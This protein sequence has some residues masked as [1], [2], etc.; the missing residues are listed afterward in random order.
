[1]KITGERVSTPDGGFN[2]T[3]QRHAAAY[4]LAEPLLP[5]G[6]VVDLGCG[7]GHSFRLLAPRAT[8][9]V[10]V[11]PEALAGQERETV[12]ADMRRLPFAD[13]SFDAAIAVQSIEHVPDPETALSEAA[14]VLR[15]GGVAI[16][17]TPNR[18][19]FGRPD[20]II[21]PFHYVELDAQELRALCAR[22]FE[23]VEAAGIFGSPR[24]MEIFTAERLKL[25]RLLRLDPLRARRLL[26]RRGRQGLYDLL[27][28]RN[29][30][31]HDPRAAAI[32]I[33]D[34]E[35]GRENL[36]AALDV[37]AICSKATA[38]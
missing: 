22:A 25:D 1:M 13:E 16:F 28:R 8:V 31:A 11:D 9:G 6:S 34:F 24:Y 20:E 17:V 37:V 32:A 4:A 26:P 12:E 10:D 18:L 30:R 36:Q 38:G 27:L 33:A 3:W 29:R 15:P 35:L 14:R 5:A 7:V 2:P 19:T 21:D 23:T